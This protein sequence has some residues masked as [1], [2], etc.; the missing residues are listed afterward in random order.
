MNNFNDLSNNKIFSQ[1]CVDISNINKDNIKND[2]FMF[3]FKNRINLLYN[4]K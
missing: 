4:N 1:K 3:T 2:Y